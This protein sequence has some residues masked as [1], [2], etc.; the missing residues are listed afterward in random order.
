MDA[1]PPRTDVLTP[2]QRREL[3]RRIGTR[4]TR[5]ELKLRRLLFADGLRYRLAHAGLRWRPDLIFVRQ[6]VVVFVHGCFWHGHGCNLFRW[7]RSNA[8]FWQKKLQRNV[9]R[10][11]RVE[12]ELSAGGWRCLTIW[13]CALRG[14]TRLDGR[15][16]IATVRGF[17]ASPA[18]TTRHI[19]HRPQA[20]L[21]GSAPQA[22]W[23]PYI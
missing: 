18:D 23:K 13:E 9:A 3:M 12:N 8:A 21:E 15:D 20:E 2:Q 7:P 1:G 10:D 22:P 5:P 16:L 4:D 14:P 17:L 19:P 6:R 11:I